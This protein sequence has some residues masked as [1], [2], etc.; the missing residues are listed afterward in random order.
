[1]KQS[2][3]NLPKVSVLMVTYNH[4][5][6]I[7]QAIESI[8]IQETNFQYEVVIG[9]DYSTDKT[10][11]IIE[12]YVQENPIKIRAIFNNKNLGMQKNFL[13]VLGACHGEYVAFLEG[14]D[15][16]TNPHKLQKQVD[17][18]ENN[19]DSMGSFHDTEVINQLGKPI[20]GNFWQDF[21][22][23]LDC[24]LKDTILPTPPFHTSS[25]I[26]RRKCLNQLPEEF[27]CFQS[28][29]LVLYI[30]SA[31][32]GAFRRIPEEMSAYRRH[33]AGI[34]QT[35][36]QQGINFYAGRIY[37]FRCLKRYLKGVESNS[38]DETIKWF[39]LPL[40]NEGIDNIV[41]IKDIFNYFTI[42][43][44]KCGLKI[45]INFM[46]RVI[47]YKIRSFIKQLVLLFS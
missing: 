33:S 21:R 4:E 43:L 34:T 13:K 41:S 35:K 17:F 6:Y 36:T 26:V 15:Y 37:M 3:N 12:D 23:R 39:E 47:N 18:L 27:L 14:D 30:V 10:R 11:E 7:A 2:T 31:Q 45:T 22:E 19:P 1:M 16:W 25:F 42:L 44:N 24:F 32:Y 8:L 9:E 46:R 28:S 20:D 40:F 5:N 38:F 29:D